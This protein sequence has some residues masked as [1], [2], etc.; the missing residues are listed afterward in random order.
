M[1]ITS[2]FSYH[3]SKCFKSL[4]EVTH[5]FSD[6]CFHWSNIN[7]FEVPNIKLPI[8]LPLGFQH[9]QYGQ[10]SD[11][12]LSSSCGGT[13]K[14]VFCRAKSSFVKSTLNSVKFLNRRREGS[15]GPLRQ[16]T[17][18]NQVLIFVRVALGGDHHFSVT[19]L[20]NFLGTFRQ[21][22]FSILHQ[23]CLLILCDGF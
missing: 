6:Q 20:F 17:N 4:L 15:S 2:K 3:Q 1:Y 18:R 11:I 7:Y 8:G 14:Q 10:Q 5:N 21:G 22:N 13:Y 16:V 12:G 19:I 9:L 23:L